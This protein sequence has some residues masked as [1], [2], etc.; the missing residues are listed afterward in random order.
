MEELTDYMREK[1]K[2]FMTIL[3]DLNLPKATVEGETAMFWNNV[4]MMNEMVDYIEI[5][6][7]ATETQIIDKA[8][9]ISGR[10]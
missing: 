10:C 4:D 2:A 8:I 6:T 3:M 9:E 5:N 7:N 1:T